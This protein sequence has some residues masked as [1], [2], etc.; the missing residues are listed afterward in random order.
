[1]ARVDI[2]QV[3]DIIRQVAADEILPR[4]RNLAADDIE[5]KSQSGDLVTV[6]DHAA[7]AA[8]TR[9]LRDLL[10]G[11]LVVGEEAVAADAR[12][13]ELF[14]EPGPVWVVDPIDGTRNFTQGGTTFD[15]MVGLVVGGR[16]VAGWIYAPAEDTLFLGEVGSG[17]ERTTAAGTAPIAAPKGLS[18]RDSEGI[19][20]ASGFR[21]RGLTDPA[22]VTDRFRGFVRPTCAGH[23]YGRLLGGASQFLVNFSTHPWDHLPGLAIA[24]AA[25]FRA[26][27]HDRAPF[28]PLD[29]LGGILVAAD[30]ETWDAIHDLLLRPAAA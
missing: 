5:T 17:A 10:P 18:L 19:L 24:H 14:R 26:A 13:L 29:R 30:G 22:R 11:S 12:R 15:V 23:N 16:P 7:E 27:R 28:D 9:R 20:M 25:G 21:S 8:L 4:W 3:A 2:L 6:A 1:M